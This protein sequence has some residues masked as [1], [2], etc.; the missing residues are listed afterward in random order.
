[1]MLKTIAR[2]LGAASPDEMKGLRLETERGYWVLEG[3][4]DLSTFLRALPTLISGP[5]FLYFEGGSPDGE[6]KDWIDRNM[7]EPIEQVARGTIWPRCEVF[8]IPLAESTIE[9][10]ALISERIAH[11]ELA[12]HTHAYEP[13]RMIL[14][15]HDAFDNPM[16]IDARIGEDQVTDFA[17][18]I[19]FTVMKHNSESG[20]REI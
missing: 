7:I 2:L 17:R 8:H 9:E 18:A 13:G 6:L 19:G 12:I 16:L 20:R 10:L 15:W 5:A 1:M 3:D 11:P 14:E 4:T